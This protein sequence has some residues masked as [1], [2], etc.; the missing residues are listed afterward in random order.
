M[1]NKTKRV[2]WGF[3]S[4][5]YKAIE[6]YLEEMAEKG[7]MLEKV[8]RMT[9][10]FRAIE[11]KKL[12]FYVD[13]FKEGGPLTPENTKE[14]EEYRR[15]CQE[16]GW[17]FITSQD[18]LQ[19]FY[20]DGDKNPIPIQTDEVLEQKIVETTLWR[21]E[22]RS[23]FIF[24]IIA[25]I[26]L[27]RYFPIKH[28]NLLS[29][30]GVAGTLLF[31]LLC[32]S[33]LASTVYGL[34]RV[35][36]ARRNV[37]RGL[38]I[39]KPTLKSARRR[40]IAFH[41]P[42]LTIAFIFILAFVVDAFFMPRIVMLS[43]LG[44]VLG[45][46]IGLGL[47]YFIKKKTTDKKDSVIYVTLSFMFVIF[48]LLIANSLLINRP[49]THTYKEDSIPDGYPIVTVGELLDGSQQGSLVSREFD[50]GMSPITPKHY[51]YREI[52]DFNGER[53]G[54]RV[55]YYQT[56]HPYFAE[57]I[58]NGIT[59][60]LKRGIKWRGMYFLTKTIITDDKMKALWDVDYLALT[61]DR[62]EMIIQ[63]GNIVVHLEGDIDFEDR[64]LRDLIIDRFSM[65]SQL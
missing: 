48:A 36:R 59:E 15:L 10:K 60:E 31:P 25:V 55:H 58:F 47:R 57:V 32:I 18:Y 44:P 54:I 42:A 4:L 24:S 62:D 38:P 26:A 63:K 49:V 19:F 16:S 64:Q 11:P 33:I 9:A 53:K 22:L 20:A 17:T 30:V 52:R 50:F 12:K 35:L 61:E 45:M 2:F 46:G 23:L 51:N 6:A 37:K 1:K 43:L 28:N 5:D 7:W 34:M 14:A 40:I 29:F 39:E 41:G 13:V 65:D 27:V 3:F 21:G 56:I 8:G